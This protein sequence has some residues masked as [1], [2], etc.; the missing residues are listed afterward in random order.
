MN[1]NI[2]FINNF[3]CYNIVVKN[4][5]QIHVIGIYIMPQLCDFTKK[6]LK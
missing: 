1:K 2:K 4:S 6:I 5:A 3:L